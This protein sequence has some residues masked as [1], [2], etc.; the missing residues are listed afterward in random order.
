MPVEDI[1]KLKTEE[2]CLRQGLE[3]T[4]G[5]EERWKPMNG[6]EKRLRRRDPYMKKVMENFLKIETPKDYVKTLGFNFKLL[7][8]SRPIRPS[9]TS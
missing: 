7:P 6:Q 8:L 5:S 4:E 9:H 2:A 1:T 3:K